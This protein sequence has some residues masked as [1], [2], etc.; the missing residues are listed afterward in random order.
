[1]IFR[2]VN[3][4]VGEFMTTKPANGTFL[5]PVVFEYLA[6]SPSLDFLWAL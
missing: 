5:A 1:M 6:F 4:I 2:E 3:A